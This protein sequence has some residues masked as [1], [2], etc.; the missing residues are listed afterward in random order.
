MYLRRELGHPDR[1]YENL[2]DLVEDLA[3]LYTCPVHSKELTLVARDYESV[4]YKKLD[5][6]AKMP[7]RAHETDAGYDLFALYTQ[8]LLP[9][10]LTEVYTG[11][12]IACPDN[13]YFTIEGKSTYNVQRVITKRGIFDSGYRGPIS[14]LMQNES[15]EVIT[16]HRWQKFAQITFHSRVS[17]HMVVADEL[18]ESTRGE[19]RYGSTGAF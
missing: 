18:P 12:A 2:D 15:D 13:L 19:G 1:K 6:G 16:I 3:S 8:D 11:I 7:E 4:L 5:I 10:K 9:N 14:A 17:V